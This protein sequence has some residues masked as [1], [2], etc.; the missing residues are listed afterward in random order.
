MNVK[1]S[2]LSFLISCMLILTLSTSAYAEHAIVITDK[3][4]TGSY[5]SYTDVTMTSGWNTSNPCRFVNKTTWIG[6][7]GDYSKPDW[8][9]TGRTAGKM[10]DSSGSVTC[11]G[12]KVVGINGNYAAYG[13]YNSSGVLTY[14]E[15]GYN[16]SHSGTHNF[17][18]QRTSA[19][20]WK[21]YFDLGVIK[22][23]TWNKTSGFDA[24]VGLEVNNSVS[25]IAF[26][27]YTTSHQTRSTSG[28]WSNWTNGQI[29]DA[30]DMY[31]S[32][33]W[34]VNFGTLG[35]SGSGGPDYSK[36]TYTN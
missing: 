14:E 13:K 28:T 27:N 26:P 32:R 7:N 35:G 34:Y 31:N 36:A 12:L 15:W 20:E 24:R 3:V 4:N 22:T 2:M 10:P 23:F 18:I 29:I 9:E 1:K 5:F 30:S 16:A 6:F 11:G 21:A 8:L 33:N 19:T 17:Q 25:T